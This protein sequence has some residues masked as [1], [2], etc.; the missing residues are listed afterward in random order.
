MEDGAEVWWHF[1]RGAKSVILTPNTSEI[2]RA[3]E[4]GGK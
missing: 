2:A 3:S 4:G 1:D